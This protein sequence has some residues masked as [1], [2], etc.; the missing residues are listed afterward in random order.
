MLFF[1]DEAAALTTTPDLRLLL[2]ACNRADIPL[3]LNN[4]VEYFLYYFQTSGKP[5]F[6]RWLSRSSIRRCYQLRQ[7]YRVLRMSVEVFLC[8]FSTAMPTRARTAGLW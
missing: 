1:V 2:R 4:K 7:S 6:S 3:A 5:S 8:A